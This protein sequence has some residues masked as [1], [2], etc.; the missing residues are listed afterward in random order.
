MTLTKLF[1]ALGFGVT[2]GTLACGLL[3]PANSPRAVKFDC[4][5]AALRPVLGEILDT[6]ALL[7]DLYAGKASLSAALTAAGATEAEVRA[8]VAGLRACEAPVAEP[9]E[10]DAGLTPS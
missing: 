4:Q 1:L 6:K 8:V 9:V 7:R 5:E 3:A 2:V 10:P